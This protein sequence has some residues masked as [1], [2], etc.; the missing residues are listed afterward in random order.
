MIEEQFSLT[1]NMNS[2]FVS[3]FMHNDDEIN[4]LDY[5]RVLVRR[6][7]LVGFIVTGAFIASIIY[8][9]AFFFRSSMLPL[10]VSSLHTQ[11]GSVGMAGMSRISP[12]G[13]F[14]GLSGG[15]LGVKSPGDLWV[16]ILKSQT[17][18]DAIINRFDLDKRFRTE[19]QLKMR[20]G[21]S[22]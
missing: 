21:P 12:S 19:V 22:K 14:G 18:W 2:N 20:E 17:V 8:W 9:S 6:N 1:I 11:E 13:G 3:I 5:W 15:F 4:L 10:P 16:G 7:W